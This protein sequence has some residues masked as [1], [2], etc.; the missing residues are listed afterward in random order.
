MVLPLP[1]EVRAG[2][3]RDAGYYIY[4]QAGPTNRN[5]PGMWEDTAKDVR[6]KARRAAEVEVEFKDEEFE[7]LRGFVV[8]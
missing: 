3:Y 8:D 6:R 2:S 7:D 1:P 4:Q 5:F